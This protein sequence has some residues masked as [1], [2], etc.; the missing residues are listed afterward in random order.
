MSIIGP[1]NF[2]FYVIQYKPSGYN[3]KIEFLCLNDRIK[4]LKYEEIENE[5]PYYKTEIYYFNRINNQSNYIISYGN[6][7]IKQILNQNF[8]FQDKLICFSQID[9]TVYEKFKLYKKFIEKIKPNS[10]DL[11]ILL[12]TNCM[13]LFGKTKIDFLLFIEV[14]NYFQL[15]KY[16]N[17][18]DNLL[19]LLTQSEIDE[20]NIDALNKLKEKYLSLFEEFNS[21]DSKENVQ[22]GL[23]IIKFYLYLCLDFDKF[24]PYYNTMIS[25]K[26]KMEYINIIISKNKTIERLFIIKKL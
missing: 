10:N 2:I 20:I 1:D 4:D 21:E 25:N 18:I 16:D 11:E 8:T 24:E 19:E 22:K 12:Y 14:V 17:Y 3:E 5:K 15:M 26:G 7:K 23:L 13:D 9:L 6:K